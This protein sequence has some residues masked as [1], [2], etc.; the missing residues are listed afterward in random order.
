MNK[1]LLKQGIKATANF[2]A[3]YFIIGSKITSPRPYI[4][5]VPAF[6]MGFMGIIFVVPKIIEGLLYPIVRIF[7]RINGLVMIPINNVRTTKI[8]IN[9]IRLITISTKYTRILTCYFFDDA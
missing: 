4:T 5:A 8:L 7:R 1:M 3:E 9:N 6:F 2:K